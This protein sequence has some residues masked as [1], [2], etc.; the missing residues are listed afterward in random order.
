MQLL[1]LIDEVIQE[2]PRQSASL[3]GSLPIGIAGP[4]PMGLFVALLA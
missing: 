3:L 4:G 1:I 2:P